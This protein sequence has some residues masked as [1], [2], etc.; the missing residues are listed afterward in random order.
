MSFFSILISFAEALSLRNRPNVFAYVSPTSFFFLRPFLPSL[1]SRTQRIFSW[2]LLKSPECPT[3]RILITRKVNCR[4]GRFVI[5]H[6]FVYSLLYVVPKSTSK[7]DI[8]WENVTL[9]ILILMVICRNML[10]PFIGCGVQ[11]SPR[12]L[13]ARYIYSLKWWE[14][15]DGKVK[16]LFFPLEILSDSENHLS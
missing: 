13:I 6:V 8:I 2:L 7:L 16:T 4:F 10:L 12:E 14:S 5:V 9:F 11:F 3:V 1:N 15:L